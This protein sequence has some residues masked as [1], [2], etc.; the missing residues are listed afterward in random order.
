V[1]AITF[2]ASSVTEIGSGLAPA[3]IDV[4]IRGVTARFLRNF[5][6]DK[7]AQ[8]EGKTTSDVCSQVNKPRTKEGRVSFINLLEF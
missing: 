5:V 7:I 3:G 4:D 2:F 6:R 8:L 1:N